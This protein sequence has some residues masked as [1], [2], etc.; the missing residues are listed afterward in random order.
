MLGVNVSIIIISYLIGLLTLITPWVIKRLL[1]YKNKLRPIGKFWGPMLNGG[2]SIITASEEREPEIKSQVFDFL[3]TSDIEK[4]FD[5]MFAGKHRLCTCGSLSQDTLKKNMFLVGGPIPNDVTKEVLSSADTRYYFEGNDI[6]DKMSPDF[7]KKADIK[8]GIVV[9]DYGIITKCKNPFRQD[10][11]VIIGS[12]CYGWGTW[13]ALEALLNPQNLQFLSGK[14]D[15]YFQILVSVNVFRKLPQEPILMKDT[16]KSIGG[17]KTKR[18]LTVFSPHP[19]DETLACGGTLAKKIM[20]RDEV[21]VMFMTDGRNSHKTVF[22]IRQ[23][24]TPEEVKVV[25]KNEAREVAKILGIKEDN[26]VFLDF[27]DSTLKDNIL[28]AED[29]VKEYLIKLKPTEIFIPQEEDFHKDHSSTNIIVLSAVKGLFLDLDVYEYILWSNTDKKFQDLSKNPNFI[30]I[31]VS[32]TVNL[33]IKAIATYKSQVDT[34]FPSQTRPI[35]DDAFL[36]NF[37]KPVEYFLKYKIQK[38]NK[39]NPQLVRNKNE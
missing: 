1:D 13:G 22:N 38:G 34:L 23:N 29:I 36:S 30:E 7:C 31:D 12:G 33:K 5:R 24:P 16:Y 17:Q 6:R 4:E 28:K 19:D 9:R 8:N 32:D 27:E 14:G 3:A 20:G 11:S 21:Y 15:P 25:R 37:K 26:I 39:I 35:L 2:L 10:R 18:I